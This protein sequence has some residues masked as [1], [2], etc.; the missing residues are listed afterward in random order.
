MSHP[1]SQV[2]TVNGVRVEAKAFQTNLW[3]YKS[4][5]G[6]VRVTGARAELI[7]IENTYFSRVEGTAIAVLAAS[8]EKECRDTSKCEVKHWAVGLGVTIRF[9]GGGAGP[10]GIS[11]LLP[12]HGIISRATVRVKGRVLNFTTALGS[13]PG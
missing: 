5:G 7:R 8:H 11:D 1:R 13:Y 6:E 9:P 4:I 12:L 3:A 10:S 2:Q